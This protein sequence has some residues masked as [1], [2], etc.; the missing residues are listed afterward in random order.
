[1]Y[2]TIDSSVSFVPSWFNILFDHSFAF[3]ST[4]WLALLALLPVLWWMSY[5]GLSGLGYWR[6]LWA[7]GLRS[8]VFAAI[9]FALADMQ[10]RKESDRLT[11]IYLLDQSLS[12]PDEQRQ[13]MKTF[14]NASVRS[15]RLDEKQDR[16]G[17]IVFGRDAEVELP[18]VDFN[19]EMPRIESAVDRQQTN[20]AAAL[21]AGDGPLPARCGQAGR[22][23]HRRE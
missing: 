7:L 5:G 6:R 3:D 14:V 13:A 9:V 17:V 12:I 23:R 1:M 18:P 21:G 16:V 19:Y 2:C 10:L 11:V 8:L 22:H 20:L 15:H 4:W